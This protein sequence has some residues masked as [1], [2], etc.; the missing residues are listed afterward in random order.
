M[1]FLYERKYKFLFQCFC[2][3]VY[4]T[5]KFFQEILIR[6]KYAYIFSKA[7]V[8]IAAKSEMYKI[9]WE[10]ETLESVRLLRKSELKIQYLFK[11]CV[12]VLLINKRVRTQLCNH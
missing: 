9:F 11:C 6:F 5:N 4:L 10:N 8:L 3:R 2:L 1:N 12:L 7:S